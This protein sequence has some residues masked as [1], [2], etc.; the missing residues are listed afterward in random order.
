[1]TRA[2]TVEHKVIGQGSAR[3]RRKNPVA[4]SAAKSATKAANAHE[5]DAQGKK[6]MNVAGHAHT[7]ATQTT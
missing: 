6:S 3:G 1:M 7:A 4:G 2:A 5:E